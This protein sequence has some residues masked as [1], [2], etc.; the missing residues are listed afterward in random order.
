MHLDEVDHVAVQDAVDHV[1]DAPPRISASAQ[2]NRRWPPCRRSIQTMKTA[3]TA[4]RP[5]KN[6]RCQPLAP[7]RNENAA[8]V[9]WA[10]TMLKNGVMVRQSPSSKLR[11]I[12]GLREL[13]EQR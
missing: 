10:R 7:A 8:P 9:L 5:M 3:A 12:S 2:Q 13:V 4:P 11:A 6:Q 1:A